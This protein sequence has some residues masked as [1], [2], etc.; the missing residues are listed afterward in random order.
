M[1]HR[2][3]KLPRRISRQLRIR[4]ER[5]HV[6]DRGQYVRLADHRRKAIL[7]SAP[8]Q[9]VQVS[10]LAPLPLISHPDALLGIPTTWSVKKKKRFALFAVVLVI[11][12]LDSGLGQPYQLFIVCNGFLLGI[13]QVSEERKVQVSIPIGEETNFERLSKVVDAACILKQRRDDHQGS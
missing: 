7:C 8:E 3:H 4:V 11:Q 13:L 5:D 12:R 2:R 1:G 6:F 9:S 10:K